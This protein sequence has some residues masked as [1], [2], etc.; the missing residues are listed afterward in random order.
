MRDDLISVSNLR[1][2][3][4]IYQLNP[5]PAGFGTGDATIL[6]V[7]LLDSVGRPLSWIVGG[8]DVILEIRCLAHKDIFRPIVGFQF[9]DRLG[10]I[11]FCDNTYLVYRLNPVAIS[12]G[13]TLVTRFE[14]RLPILPTGD[15]TISPAIAEGS[16]E[17]H[18]QLHW[19]HDALI[20][21]VHASFV[22]MGLVGLPI[23]KII[24]ESQ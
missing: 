5:D 20:L 23:K 14:F 7:R 6:S 24:M 11:I 8:E 4:E 18:I 3:V 13:A 17:Q 10:Q 12:N 21:K 1:N 19:L 2:D 15:Y 16:Q 22:V 9:K